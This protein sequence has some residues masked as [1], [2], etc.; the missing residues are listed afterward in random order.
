MF[1]D[2][3]RGIQTPGTEF[4]FMLS[5]EIAPQEILGEQVAFD[6][7]TITGFFSGVGERIFIRGNL[8]TTAY[9]QCANCLAPAQAPIEVPF[10]ETFARDAGSDDLDMFTFEGSKV[11]FAELALSLSVLALPMR[12]LCREDC[13]GLCGTCGKDFNHCTCQKETGVRHPFEALQQLLT[14]DEEV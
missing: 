1:L 4:P 3:T 8:T 6:K 9:A 2:V 13:Q 10:T 11:D 5:E 14:K 12:F 7:A